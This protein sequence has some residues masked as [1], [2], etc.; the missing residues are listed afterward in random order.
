MCARVDE[1]RRMKI[2]GIKRTKQGPPWNR[3]GREPGQRGE[4]LPPDKTWAK[5]KS[6]MWAEWVKVSSGDLTMLGQV[7][8]VTFKAVW[9]LRGASWK[10]CFQASCPSL[11]NWNLN[12][13]DSHL[14]SFLSLTWIAPTWVLS[15]PRP[16]L[17]SLLCLEDRFCFGNWAP[18]S[19]E[20]TRNWRQSARD[21]WLPHKS[22]CLLES[23]GLERMTDRLQNRKD[24]SPP[25][26]R[27]KHKHYLFM[28]HL[29]GD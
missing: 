10:S 25:L 21:K 15:L 4:D 8:A 18:C 16:W 9:L 3:Q 12:S 22:G 20:T 17:L 29:K 28:R 19:W 11:T 5:R 26:G 14:P 13:K 6:T 23:Q 7:D 24:P 1:R 27:Q 2:L